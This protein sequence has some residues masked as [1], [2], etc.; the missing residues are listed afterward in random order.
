MH[1]G[2]VQR[3]HKIKMEMMKKGA[4]SKVKVPVAIYARKSTK[5]RTQMSL[6]FQIQFC[7]E[8]LSLCE[9]VEVV[10]EYSEDNKSGYRLKG[11]NEFAKILDR[12]RNGDVKVVICYSIDRAYRNIEDFMATERL[13][14]ENGAVMIYAS[15]FFG[16][17]ATDKHFKRQVV[18]QGMQVPE[19]A[20]E[21]AL[22]GG[23][24]KAKR[25]EYMGG[26][27]PY[28]YRVVENKYVINEDEAPAVKELF[29]R[30]LARK[31]IKE[32]SADL[33]NMGYVARGTGKPFSYNTLWGML[34]NEMYTGTYIYYKANA[35]KRET[36]V[37]NEK[38]DEVRVKGGVPE[39]VS[40]ETFAKVQEIIS[41]KSGKK[42][43]GGGEGYALTGILKDVAG[44]NI[45]MHGEVSYGGG[46]RKKYTNYVSK[47]GSGT[48]VTVRTE[49]M[50]TAAANILLA[51][52]QR[53]CTKS[54]ALEK[55]FKALEG[56][57]RTELCSMA[58]KIVG[59]DNRAANAIRALSKVEDKVA[60]EALTE[61]I[62]NERKLK[63]SL[64]ER[65][66]TL[67]K[68]LN[69]IKSFIKKVKSKEVVITAED[70]L[71][72]RGIFEKLISVVFERIE[73]DNSQV[74][75]IINE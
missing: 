54:D 22:D 41:I 38:V 13:F 65:E 67:R 68:Q 48:G 31:G 32:I 4:D 47:R 15:Q 45:S 26:C 56:S 51:W 52:L 63:L 23:P 74:V 1:P 64:L 33:A 11:R 73:M 5:D 44:G 7:H 16:D 50:D 6:P 24:N 17:T 60:I 14:E 25:A 37:S 75:F 42:S 66:E 19:S 30:A 43:G 39:L 35:R 12:V 29:E 53:I 8:A 9:E 40:P 34:R 55:T 49:Y 46:S 28:G 71:R 61:T 2:D 58:S 21:R 57:M 20:S 36:R 3:V 18:V 69:S 72:D 70:I 10:G 27:I 62:L 59:A